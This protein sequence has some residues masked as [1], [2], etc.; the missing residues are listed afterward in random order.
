MSAPIADWPAN[1]SRPA[2]PS[3]APPTRPAA[4]GFF[5]HLNISMSPISSGLVEFTACSSLSP[6]AF[7]ATEMNYGVQAPSDTTETEI[8]TGRQNEELTTHKQLT[9]S[10]HSTTI[11]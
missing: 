7:T 10:Q 3:P 8:Y 11:P 5:P 9:Y 6:S 2:S 1:Q 4:V